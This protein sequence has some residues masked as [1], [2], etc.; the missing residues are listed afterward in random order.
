[1]KERKT[2]SRCT[3]VEQLS[4]ISKGGGGPCKF[5]LLAIKMIQGDIG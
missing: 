1:M 5:I 4:E 3:A 2:Q